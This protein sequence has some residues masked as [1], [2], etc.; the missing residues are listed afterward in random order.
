MKSFY[1]ASFNFQH[2]IKT[3]E[4]FLIKD[5]NIFLMM[6]KIT[7]YNAQKTVVKTD[8]SHKGK[9][10]NLNDN[11]SRIVSFARKGSLSYASYIHLGYKQEKSRQK[12]VYQLYLIFLYCEAQVGEVF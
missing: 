5:Y 3:C 12:K 7:T 9:L 8:K 1:P 10:D 2:I 4:T 11:L 6:N